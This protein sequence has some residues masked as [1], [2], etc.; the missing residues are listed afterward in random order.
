MKYRRQLEEVIGLPVMTE[1]LLSL[2]LRCKIRRQ[3]H[4]PEK[5][6]LVFAKRGNDFASRFGRN[7]KILLTLLPLKRHSN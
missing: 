5:G 4:L 3:T 6:V 1:A 2:P 7:K